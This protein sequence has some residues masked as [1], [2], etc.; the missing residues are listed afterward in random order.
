M[1]DGKMNFTNMKK[2]IEK[3]GGLFYQYRPCKRNA[4]TIYDIENIRHGVI[5]AQTPLNMNDPFDSMIGFSAEKVYAECV[6]MI[7]NLLETDDVTKSLIYVLLQYRT[8]GKMAELILSLKE[9]KA[10]IIQKRKVMHQT[11]ISIENFINKNSGSLYKNAAKKFRSAFSEKNFYA[12]MVLVGRIGNCDVTED[13]ISSMLKMDELLSNIHMAAEEL[14]D[15]KYKEELK[16]FLSKVTVSCFSASGWNNQLMWS[17]YANSYSGI[18][19][20][21]DF[22]KLKDFTGFIYP[23][24]YTDERPT[25]SM[26]DVGI[27]GLSK[28]KTPE[29]VTCDIDVTYILSY[30]L[31][32]NSCWKYEKE[33]RI[34]NVGEEY[35]PIFINLPYIKSITFGMKVDPICKKLL[36]EI[37]NDKNIACYDLVIST[38]NYSISRELIDY[39]LTS[40][41]IS[42]EIKFIQLLSNQM[43][44]TTER[45][46]NQVDLV[47]SSIANELFDED[48]LS[49]SLE[50]IL[51]FLSNIYF[52]KKS[53]NRVGFIS[54][55]E[56]VNFP[57]PS[58]V[59]TIINL[60]EASIV[61]FSLVMDILDKSVF[62]L[63]IQG[64]IS[65]KDYQKANTQIKNICELIEKINLHE[66][67]VRFLNNSK[68]REDVIV[69]YDSLVEEE[70]DPVFDTEELREYMDKWDGDTFVDAMNLSVDKKVLEIGVGTGRLALKVAP[71]CAEFI[72][73]D[74]SPK[75]IERAMINLKTN[76][77]VKLICEDFTIWNSTNMKFD[78]VYSSLTF[79]HISNKFLTIKKV[80]DLLN[81]NG[82]FVLS[83]DKSQ[84]D[85]IDYGTRKVLIYP[86]T[87]EN[88]KTYVSAVGMKIENILNT[89]FSYVIV[90]KK[91]KQN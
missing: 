34:I 52:I 47:T 91:E 1:V 43:I 40:N 44:K 18:C 45:M 37:C 65:Y 55:D 2:N 84:N 68:N 29:I 56:L 7:V 17:H 23:I 74:I 49:S 76:E 41:D 48:A 71:R 38:E 57:I 89:E 42:E 83:I 26:R 64:K 67:D 61:A 80:Y 70:N 25:L 22:S 54:G 39:N 19:V 46:N 35:T 30:M 60:A 63:T 20:E 21:Y 90:L 51:D 72:G 13:N 32:K 12:L 10:Y 87:L 85:Y 50:E 11:V 77:N 3:A 86:D 58:G 16:R 59:V 15:T 9:I 73:I 82:I 24:K 27:A 66:W 62:S 6:S 5:Y 79:M 36:L 8:F 33:W 28:G 4:E 78:I 53:I 31:C 14:R 88:I 75:S 69:H 81:D